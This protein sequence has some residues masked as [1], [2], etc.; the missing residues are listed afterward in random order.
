MEGSCGLVVEGR[1]GEGAAGHARLNEGRVDAGVV[2][3]RGDERGV[4]VDA[5][6]DRHDAGARFCG[7]DDFAHDVGSKFALDC[8]RVGIPG[9]GGFVDVGV[10]ALL[11]IATGESD[12]RDAAADSGVGAAHCA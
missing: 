11:A 4:D 3:E 9:R 1:V 7:V 8:R 6:A 12:A 10:A 2:G 5:I